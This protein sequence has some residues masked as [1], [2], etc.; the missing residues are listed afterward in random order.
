MR[1]RY[2]AV[3]VVVLVISS[4]AAISQGGV[5]CGGY[6]WRMSG[7]VDGRMH[8]SL[9]LFGDG[10]P[11]IDDWEL[12]AF[13]V[14]DYDTLDLEIGTKI[15]PLV[16]E[17]G[18]TIDLYGYAAWWPATGD[19]FAMPWLTIEGNILGGKL[20][21]YQAEYVPINGGPWI[22]FSSDTSLMW[23]V[24]DDVDL[25]LKAHWWKQ[26]GFSTPVH[27]GFKAKK[28]I[29]KSCL[30]MSYCPFGGGGDTFWTTV[31]GGF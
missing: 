28:E 24:S 11:E 17:D 19:W 22:W 30:E 8:H 5:N 14:D 1:F 3:S 26:E 2:V 12:W 9:A 23:P 18:L 16:Q 7:E 31:S 10:A 4:Y 6:L 20:K 15:A 25:G 29:G 21:S 27:W 13:N